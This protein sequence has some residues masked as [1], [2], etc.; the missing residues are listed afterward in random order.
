M[1]FL[2]GCS[3]RPLFGEESFDVVFCNCWAYE[4]L[5]SYAFLIVMTQ[6]IS[7]NF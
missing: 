4:K 5:K 3:E 2:F 7:G 1:D 6:C